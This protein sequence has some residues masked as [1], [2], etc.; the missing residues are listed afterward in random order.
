LAAG[1]DGY[2]SKPIR[3][4][5]LYAAL[6]RVSP[7]APPAEPP[8]PDSVLDRP[9]ILAA[10]GGDQELLDELTQLFRKRSPALLAG[11]RD[12]V[13]NGDAAAVARAAH[14]CKGVVATFSAAAAG[15]AR[16]LEHMGRTGELAGAGE[17]L[18]EL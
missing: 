13:A 14:A 3:A 11:V 4:A 8:P 7:P 17:R 12:A 9:T 16:A 5:E 18:A 15:V 6:E 10:C 1:M 2:L